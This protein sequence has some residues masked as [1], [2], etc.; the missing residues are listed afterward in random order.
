M[1]WVEGAFISAQNAAC[2][3]CAKPSGRAV[4]LNQEAGVK[5]VRAK[6][7]W[8]CTTRGGSSPVMKRMGPP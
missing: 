4:M 6:H 2:K 8:L 7:G 3:Q 5:G 1:S